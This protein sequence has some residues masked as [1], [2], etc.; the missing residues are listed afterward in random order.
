M[1]SILIGSIG[2][3]TLV[4]LFAVQA[5]L[6]QLAERYRISPAKM[7]LA[8]NGAALGMA[9][10]GPLAAATLR[11]IARRTAVWTSL[12]SLAIPTALLAFAPSLAA[13][14]S[15]RILQ[16]VFMASAF[17]LTLAHLGE[18]CVKADAP[19]ALAAYVTGSVMANLL[20]RLIASAVADSFG[21]TSAFLTFSALNA[22]GA[23]LAFGALTPIAPS[24]SDS[25]RG[26]L[27]RSF[28]LHLANPAL[29]RAYA[30]GF[31]ILFTFVGLFSYVGFALVSPRIGLSMREAG[32]VFLC[33]LPSLMTTPMAGRFA[34]RFGSTTSTVGSLLLALAGALATLVGDIVVIGVGLAVFAAGAFFAQAIVTSFVGRAAAVERATASGLYLSAYYCGGLAGAGVIGLLYERIGWHGSEPDPKVSCSRRSCVILGFRSIGE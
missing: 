7:G 29:Q 9:L 20:G 22:G 34:T 32:F 26:D 1:R 2:F 15:L 4:D 25:H 30:L 11:G 24:A 28:T 12:A 16:G 14:A 18:R 8:V 19:R 27:L 17:T 31:L 13:F 21:A 5:I 23:L 10:A 33:F 6:P 3:L